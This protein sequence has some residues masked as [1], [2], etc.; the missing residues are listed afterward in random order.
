MDGTCSSLLYINSVTSLCEMCP[1]RL[2][3]LKSLEDFFGFKKKKKDFSHDAV[4]KQQFPFVS[5]FP[6]LL[7]LF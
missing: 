2:L 4:G 7:S 3:E 1:F 6:R 5:M